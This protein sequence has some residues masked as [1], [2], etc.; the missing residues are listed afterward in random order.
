MA[1]AMLITKDNNKAVLNIAYAY[2]G[3]PMTYIALKKLS[4]PLRN[5]DIVKLFSG[6][7]EIS[8]SIKYT[9][10]G[11][12]KNLISSDSVSQDLLSKALYTNRSPIPDLLIRTSGEV[13]IS[14]FM[15]WQ[16]YILI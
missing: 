15:L 13:R 2:T 10:G 14:D 9:V 5:A 6:R 8:Q 4:F 1:K 3:M 12:V 11:V 7:E 16:V